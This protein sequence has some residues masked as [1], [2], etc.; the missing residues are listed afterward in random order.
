[1]PRY[2]IRA[3]FPERDT[4]WNLWNSCWLTYIGREGVQ[5]RLLLANSKEGC[6][7]ISAALRGLTIPCQAA[8]SPSTTVVE[9]TGLMAFCLLGAG[10]DWVFQ[11]S[12]GWIYSRVVPS[13]ICQMTD[14][15][16]CMLLRVFYEYGN[17][18]YI[19]IV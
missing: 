9:Y 2:L 19:K 7:R 3:E 8:P 17:A 15:P 4:C 5:G 6:C 12:S 1:M 10:Y 18:C 13:T 16:L 14:L 11:E